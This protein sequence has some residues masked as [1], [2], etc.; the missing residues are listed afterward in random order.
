MKKHH[1][2]SDE[3]LWVREHFG[4]T[5]PELARIF[6]Q[7]FG[8]DVS[9]EAI[10]QHCKA[11]LGLAFGSCGTRYSEEEDA[12]IKAHYMEK[13]MRNL[14]EEWRLVFP[15]H[16]VT[17]FGFKGHCQQILKLRL[18]DKKLWNNA[19]VPTRDIG[20]EHK[21]SGYIL[22][23][24]KHTKSRRGEHEDRRNW[25]FKH[26]IMWEKHNGRELR[27][28]EQVVFLNGDKNDFSKEN[29]YAVPSRW[30]AMLNTNGWLRGDRELALTGIRYC[31]LF[32]AVQDVRKGST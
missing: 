10:R 26:R 23:K 1:W 4:V 20:S 28:D 17:F 15:K 31:E 8:A 6:N 7:H 21:R 12:W 9:T 5:A 25:K 11:A 18:P 16:Q 29:L 24:V 13:P 3:D 14:Y 30:M 32:Y 19:N 22:V 27:D 2:T